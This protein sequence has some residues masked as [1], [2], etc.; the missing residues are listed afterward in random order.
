MVMSS[1]FGLTVR[2]FTIAIGPI[3]KTLQVVLA[4]LPWR[5]SSRRMDPSVF[6]TLLSTDNMVLT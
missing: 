2:D 1:S 4:A 3:L 6:V 5:D